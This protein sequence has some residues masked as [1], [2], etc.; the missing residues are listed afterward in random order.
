MP[1]VTPMTASL[2]VFPAANALMPD[3]LSRTYT[4]GNGDT[5]GDCH[6][7]DD[8]QESSLVELDRVGVDLAAA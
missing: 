5:G 4:S 1:C 8:V 6:L 2:V 3:S 7:F